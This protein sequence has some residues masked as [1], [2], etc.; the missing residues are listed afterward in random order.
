MS[1][2]ITFAIRVTLPDGRIALLRKGGVIGRGPIATYSTRAAAE[3]DIEF[4]RRHLD[5][6]AFEVF[7]RSHGRQVED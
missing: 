4:M 5:A 3:H 2:P 1:R 6:T 7:E